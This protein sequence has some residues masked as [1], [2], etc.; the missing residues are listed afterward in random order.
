[1]CSMST[2]AASQRIWRPGALLERACLA[3]R[4]AGI[5]AECGLPAAELLPAVALVLAGRDQGGV[6][7]PRQHRRALRQSGE[8]SELRDPA[9]ERRFPEIIR[10]AEHHPAFTRFNVF[11]RDRFSCQYCTSAEDL[12]FD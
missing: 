12:T 9:A 5:G 8:K 3:R 11:L 1:A 10:Q 7:R 4:L 6:P 2:H